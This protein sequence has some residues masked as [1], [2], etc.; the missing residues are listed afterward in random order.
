MDVRITDMK[1]RSPYG[2][3]KYCQLGCWE[4]DYEPGETDIPAMVRLTPQGSR[5]PQTTR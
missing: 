2:V 3:P 5:T 4:P 1:E